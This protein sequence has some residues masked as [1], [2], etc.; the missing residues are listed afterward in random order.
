[1][2]WVRKVEKPMLTIFAELIW[3]SYRL[4][5]TSY[6]KSLHG[7]N[8]RAKKNCGISFTRKFNL[9]RSWKCQQQE[10]EQTL[11]WPSDLAT[12]RWQFL[13]GIQ[14]KGQ[15]ELKTKPWIFMFTWVCWPNCKCPAF[16]CWW[17][18]VNW[19]KPFRVYYLFSADSSTSS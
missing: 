5:Y 4:P 16:K 10:F 9:H 14:E 8:P 2:L 6:R 15:L 12:K 18:S 17:V 11:W 1:M 19:E 7:E 3:F 13:H